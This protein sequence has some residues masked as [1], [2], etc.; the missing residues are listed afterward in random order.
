MAK[1]ITNKKAK[2][3]KSDKV[4]A[5]SVA[6]I[7]KRKDKVLRIKN[8]PKTFAS[9]G[10]NDSTILVVGSM[11]SIQYEEVVHPPHYNQLPNG[12]ECW[13]VTEHFPTN[14]GSAMKYLWRAGLK[15]GQDSV[16]DLKK[17]IQYTQ[18]QIDLLEGKTKSMK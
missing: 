11:E 1:H 7:M 2:Q 9:I 6:D 14:I 17:V 13:D 16:K 3:L 8:I 15:P 5:I 4:K 10:D 18:R 12:I